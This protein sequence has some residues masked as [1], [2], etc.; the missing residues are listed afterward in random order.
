[1]QPYRCDQCPMSFNVE[2]NLGLHKSTHTT[3]DPKCQVCNKKFSR[4]ASL[5]AHVMIHEKEEVRQ[6]S[7]NPLDIYSL[8]EWVIESLVYLSQLKDKLSLNLFIRR[9]IL[10]SFSL[11]IMSG[12]I[13]LCVVRTSCALSVEMNLF[14][15]VSFQ[16]ILRNIGKNSV[17]QSHTLARPAAKSSQHKTSWKNI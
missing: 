4:V 17:E 5:K 7:L 3:S 12:N 14:F 2:Y 13:M 9:K 16:C 6:L 15:R 8:N 10:M 1:M 11:C